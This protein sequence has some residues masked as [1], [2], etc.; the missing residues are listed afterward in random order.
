MADITASDRGNFGNLSLRKPPPPAATI[1]LPILTVYRTSMRTYLHPRR[2]FLPVCT[3]AR[4]IV[5]Q[6]AR[7]S[8]RVRTRCRIRVL[9]SHAHAY[10]R[11]RARARAH[12][13]TY[14]YKYTEMRHLNVS[15]YRL[16]VKRRTIDR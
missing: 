11:R 7:V 4:Y 8:A 15:A 2:T 1:P 3:V 14:L 9:P 12:T 5:S 6:R 13:H 10:V 16:W